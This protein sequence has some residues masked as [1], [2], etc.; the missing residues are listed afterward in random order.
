MKTDF[1][2]FF[3][4]MLKLEL[5]NKF[6]IDS[7]DDKR[8]LKEVY[9]ALSST[10]FKTGDIIIKEGDSGDSFYILTDGKVQIFRNTPSGD[11]IALANL[12][13]DMNIFFGETALIGKDTRSATVKAV[14]DCKTLKIS[15]KKFLELCEKEP[16]LGYRVLLCLARR[17][18]DSIKRVNI[19]MATLYE[20]LF[21]E[22]EDHR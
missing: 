2:D 5:F 12:S 7:S 19:D 8:I 6:K 11:P 1:E 15:G 4:K 17:M 16:V 18:S 20:A 14:T 10:E 9:D 3:P 21:S 22:I 13:S